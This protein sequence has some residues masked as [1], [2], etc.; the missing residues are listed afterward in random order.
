MEEMRTRPA[1]PGEEARL[2]QIK[3]AYIRS[4]YR[5]FL[6]PE[7]L[8]AATPAYY[9][10]KMA[11]MLTNPAYHVDVLESGGQAVGFIAYGEDPNDPGCGWIGEEAIDPACGRLEKDALAQHALRQ[12]QS[13]GFGV[14]HLWVL[15]DNFRVRFLFESL[16]FR[17]DGA[18]RVEPTDHQNLTIARYVCH[19][20]SDG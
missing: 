5:G 15:K 11:G 19:L 4:L 13:L 14:I 2:A 20:P 18:V 10:A 17:P 9:E 6:T 16:G 3:S 1:L 12:L 8:S 7:Y